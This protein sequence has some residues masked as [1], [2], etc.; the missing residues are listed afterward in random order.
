MPFLL[1]ILLFAAAANPYDIVIRN[2]RIIDGTG[3]PWYAGDI[4]IRAGKIAAVGHLEGQAARRSIDARGMVQVLPMELET[5][6]QVVFEK[7][8]GFR[9]G[10]N[11]IRYGPVLPGNALYPGGAGIFEAGANMAF[12]AEVLR[13]MGGF[14]EALDTGPAVPGGGD[15][16]IF[17]RVIRA[18]PRLRA[19]VPRLSPASTRNE[20]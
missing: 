17:Y 19:A 20:G 9:R 13:R 1:P 2:G 3:S 16:D 15:L 12:S 18:C 5:E 6:A 7:R 14:D 8:G 4:G 11:R 10:F